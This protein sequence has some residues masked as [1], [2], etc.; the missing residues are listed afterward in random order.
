MKQKLE[1]LARRAERVAALAAALAES[2][3]DDHP[4]LHKAVLEYRAAVVAYMADPS[5][6]KYVRKDALQYTGR[7]V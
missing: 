4:A 1:T 7:R 6:S 3:S 5:L 2:G